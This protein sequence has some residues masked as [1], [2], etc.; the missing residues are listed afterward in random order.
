M[1]AG[2]EHWNV[3]TCDSGIAG[4]GK[5]VVTWK[6]GVIERMWR[7]YTRD[8]R[9]EMI[10]ELRCGEVLEECDFVSVTPYGNDNAFREVKVWRWVAIVREDVH[11]R[12]VSYDVC[13]FGMRYIANHIKRYLH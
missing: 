2:D 11:D 1:F 7:T 9:N 8:E 5:V 12:F 4:G 10:I 3:M 6:W 13:G